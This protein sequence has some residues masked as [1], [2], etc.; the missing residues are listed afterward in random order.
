MVYSKNVSLFNYFV[1]K[2]KYLLKKLK[3][4]SILQFFAKLWNLEKSCSRSRDLGEWQNHAQ[5]QF[6]NVTLFY[7]IN[8]KSEFLDN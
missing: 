7:W 5:F 1:Y 6:K 2:S 3:Q 4:H 8:F